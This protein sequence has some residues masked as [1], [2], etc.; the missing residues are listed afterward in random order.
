MNNENGKYSSSKNT[1]SPFLL[2]FLA[3]GIF[4]LA[5]AVSYQVL[6][7]LQQQNTDSI[8]VVADGDYT[9][10][11]YD[12]PIQVSDFTSTNSVGN[13]ISLSD[14][15][16]QYVLM[17]FGYTHCPDV[18]PTTLAEFRKIKAELGESADDVIFMFISV[19]SPRDTPEVIEAYLTRFDPEFVGISI[20]DE[21]LERIEPDFGLYYDRL[22][23]E[24]RGENYLVVHTGRSFLLSPERELIMSFAYGTDA[25][26]IANG[27][28]RFKG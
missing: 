26:I 12:S 4:L 14:F 9:G 21:T 2:L 19:D 22:T 8:V 24:G 3:L 1:I 15:V 5:L 16:G 23:D 18:C 17:F 6:S 10:T 13:E 20:D 27:I 25:E 28:R 11:S 7:R